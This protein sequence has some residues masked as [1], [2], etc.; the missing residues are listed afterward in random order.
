MAS[1]S[2]TGWAT[3][4]SGIMRGILSARAGARPICA[5][6]VARVKALGGAKPALFVA[7]R[8]D[9]HRA[10]DGGNVNGRGS[11]AELDAAVILVPR[12]ARVLADRRVAAHRAVIRRFHDEA[13]L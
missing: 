8:T 13:R 7:G 2:L 9:R 3:R 6:V 5:E 4:A 1:A 12:L 11:V 10:I